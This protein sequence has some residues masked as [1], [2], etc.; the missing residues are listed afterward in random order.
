MIISHKN[1][2]I[3]IKN[4]KVASS[5]MEFALSKFCGSDDIITKIEQDEERVKLGYRG[6]QNNTYEFN[7][8]SP[9]LEIKKKIGKNIWNNYY[10][11]C[12][13]RNP[14]DKMVSRYFYFTTRKK[15]NITFKE[16]LNYSEKYLR[17]KGYFNYTINNFIVVNDIFFYEE[18]NNSLRIIEKKL[19]L[20]EKIDLPNLNAKYR[21]N[22][23]YRSF[24]DKEDK[25][26]VESVFK[27]EIELF[28]YKF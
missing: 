18:I 15:K 20:S 23:D 22:K 27:K 5:S 6:K 21:K 12:F 11:F 4:V 9:A 13:E 1:K 28:G 19:N 24:Y 8:H 3:H 25:K 2:F 14:W 26:R 7:G 17:D 10:K 16:Y